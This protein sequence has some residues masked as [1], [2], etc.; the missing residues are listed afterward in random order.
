MLLEGNAISKGVILMFDENHEM[1]LKKNED[2]VGGELVG[3][4][5]DGQLYRGTLCFII[6]VGLQESVKVKA[7]PEMEMSSDVLKNEIEGLIKDLHDTGF[8]VSAE[9]IYPIIEEKVMGLEIEG[10]TLDKD[11]NGV[12]VY[13]EE[14]DS[15]SGRLLCKYG[16]RRK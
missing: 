11:S 8:N 15:K 13:R 9:I 2:Y 6:I 16:G 10:L 1:Y 7:N 4:N 5:E 14:T 12:S 3:A